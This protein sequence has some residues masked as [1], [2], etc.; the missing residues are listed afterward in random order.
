MALMMSVAHHGPS[1]N[2]IPSVAGDAVEV[3]AHQLRYHGRGSP[4]FEGP[5][6]PQDDVYLG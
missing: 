1:L 5:D 6:V 3:S 4:S 2:R